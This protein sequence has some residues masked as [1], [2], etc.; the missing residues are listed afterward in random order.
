MMFLARIISNIFNPIILFLAFPY[1]L[2]ERATRNFQV[3]LEWE[4]I[5]VFF[6]GIVTLYMVYEVHRGVFSDLDVSRKK[7]R[8]RLF[9]F[10]SIITLLYMLVLFVLKAPF[11]L[12]AVTFGIII[13]IFI[14]SIVTIWVKASMHEATSTALFTAL[15]IAFSGWYF[16]LLLL[17]PVLGWARVK[18]K[19]HTILEVC[20]GVMIGLLLAIFVYYLTKHA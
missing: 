18:T 7:D 19:R 6:L 13:G 20:V 3:A 10:L 16:L 4:I 11:I 2:V 5:S 14:S 17:I 8:P 12:L 15:G 9:L 1:I